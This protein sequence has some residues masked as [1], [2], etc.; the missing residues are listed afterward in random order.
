MPT[1]ENELAPLV[2]ELLIRHWEVAPGSKGEWK[3]LRSSFP[4]FK[5]ER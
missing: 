5:D 4:S 3:I 2:E 1:A